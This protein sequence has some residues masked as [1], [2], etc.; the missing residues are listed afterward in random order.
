MQGLQVQQLLNPKYR[1]LTHLLF[2]VSYASFSLFS[3][4]SY[5]DDFSRAWAFVFSVLPVTILATYFFIYWVVPRILDRKK[6]VT[7]FLTFLFMALVFGYLRRW[8]LHVYY[9]PVF[10]PD[11]NYL[12]SPLLDVGKAVTNAVQVYTV[13]FA[14]IIIKLLKRNYQQ[15]Q[16]AKDLAKEKLDAE[17]KFLKGQIHPHFLFNTLN[18][19][20]S[21]TLQES[22]RAS[23]LVMKLSTLLDYILYEANVARVPLRKEVEQMK[24]LIELEQLRYGDR[25]QVAFSIR[26]DISHKYIPPLL[27]LPFVENA[28]KH[29]VS[30]EVELSFISIDFHVKGDRLVLQVEN[31]KGGAAP[32]NEEISKGIGLQN[33]RRRLEL[34]YG[35]K[36]FDLQVFDEEETFMII[37][38][39]PLFQDGSEQPVRTKQLVSAVI[40][41]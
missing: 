14:A 37:L 27:M 34:I 28:F 7:L 30:R 3:Q 40:Q 1:L 9:V 32:R 8:S 4:Y 36:N 29:G 12:D 2:W 24:N 35:S 33:V 17:L 25:L 39:I 31:S 16:I 41:G 13:V 15:E 23:E 20:Y 19:L 6:Y 10:I 5:S 26:G 22:P 11:Y 18:N 38:K 21:I